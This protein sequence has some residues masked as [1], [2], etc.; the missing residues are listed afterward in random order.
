MNEKNIIRDKSREGLKV[1]PKSSDRPPDA[2]WK[3][4]GLSEA[5][6]SSETAF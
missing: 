2:S 4:E 6:P 5:M 1:V 3:A